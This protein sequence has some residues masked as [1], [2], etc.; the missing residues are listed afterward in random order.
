M[1]KNCYNYAY[2]SRRFAVRKEDIMPVQYISKDCSKKLP[3]LL[4]CCFILFIMLAFSCTSDRIV[5]SERTAA[6]P[7]TAQASIHDPRECQ[8]LSENVFV[9]QAGAFTHV[10][11][12]QALRKKYEGKGYNAYITLSGTE[13]NKRLYR[14][15]IGRFID[16]KKAEIFAQEIKK[17][18]N[19]PAIVTLKPPQDKF[20]VQAGCFTSMNEAQILREKLS[21][22]GFNPYIIMTE[23]GT[24]KKRFIVLIGE[25]IHK[26]QAEKLADEIRKKTTVQVFVNSR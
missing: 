7:D 2:D 26:E 17:T 13:E 16:R 12:A 21:A 8:Q 11:N 20:V 25:F 19:L 3:D 1:R 23:S 15:C 22:K 14:V 4:H 9:V 5:H 24:D 6:L 10:S 18:E